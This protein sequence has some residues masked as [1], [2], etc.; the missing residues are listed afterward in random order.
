M[1]VWGELGMLA[2]FLASDHEAFLENRPRKE[3]GALIMGGG[4]WRQEPL[5]V[6]LG[7]PLTPRPPKRSAPS[8]HP[9]LQ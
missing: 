3:P 7:R 8:E 6:G 2:G 5:Q 9:Q 4:A 1:R